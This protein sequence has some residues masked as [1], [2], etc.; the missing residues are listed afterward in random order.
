MAGVVIVLLALGFIVYL[1][2]TGRG[3]APANDVAA[4]GNEASAS[5]PAIEAPPA[6]TAAAAPAGPTPGGGQLLPSGLRIETV[7]EGRGPLVTAA[8]TVHFRYELRKYG[9][10]VIESNL[11]APR[12]AVMPVAGLVPGFAE[13]LTH[14][15]PGGEARFWVPPQLG[16]G[17]N[18][19]P[20][21]PFGPN[22]T[23]EFRV[24][25]ERIG[26]PP[27][28]AAASGGNQAAAEPVPAQ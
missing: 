17:P 28:A 21:S 26:P 14:M 4:A 1:V 9:G 8:D 24:R 20:G 12:P 16:Y 3:A 11:T 25:L 15:R 7:R 6:N 19:P 18:I 2:A 5:E 23:L 10:P 27:S 13:G 22:D